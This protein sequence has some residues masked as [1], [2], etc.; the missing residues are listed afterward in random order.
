MREIG[1][2]A[3]EIDARTLAD[4]LLTR[5]ITTKLEPRTGAWAV[6][7][8]RE[9]RITEAKEVLADFEK[10]PDDPRFQ[11]ASDAA[12]VIRKQSVKIEKQYRKRVKVFRERWE[13]SMYQRA[14]LAFGL[15]VVSVIVTGLMNVSGP[16][17]VRFLEAPAFSVLAFDQD[18]VI[19][20][21]GLAQLLHGQV[22]RLVTPIFLHF[23]IMHLFFNMMVLRYLGERIEMRKGTWRFALIVV[24]AA[25]VSNFGEAWLGRH[26]NFGGMSGVIYA[27]AGY[28]WIKGHTD[29]A[30]GLSL[31]QQSVNWMLG[32]FLLGILA[33]MTA[34][35]DTPHVFPYNMA[36]LA[37]GV[38][39]VVGIVFGLLRF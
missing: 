8:H 5:N 13:G 3:R 6:W 1:T 21:V 2:L 31:S 29:P 10:N 18:G 39:L 37:H 27:L 24:V 32:W 9:E 34:G 28:L 19:R 14:P 25:I 35:P 7:V 15:I 12:R 26:S 4:Y 16:F 22:W 30:D 36:N 11:A 23:G 33:P 17:F 20:N 38:G